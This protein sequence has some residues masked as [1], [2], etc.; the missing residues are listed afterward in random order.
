M[1]I[2]GKHNV[3]QGNQCP[4]KNGNALNRLPLK[5]DAQKPDP[6]INP[7]RLVG[8]SVQTHSSH[9]FVRAQAPE[10]ANTTD[11]CGCRRSARL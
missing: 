7:P 1:D 9:E 8:E 10:F 3:D 5:D 11:G 4:V 2:Y 6:V